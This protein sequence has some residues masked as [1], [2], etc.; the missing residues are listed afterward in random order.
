MR[1]DYKHRPEVYRPMR[2]LKEAEDA[3]TLEPALLELIRIRASQLN[4]CARCLEIHAKDAR[5]MGEDPMRVDLV[6]AWRETQLYSERE[7]AALAWTEELTLLTE[8]TVPDELYEAT[9]AVLS[10]DEVVQ[11]GASA[12]L[13]QLGAEIAPE[14]WC[15][16]DVALPVGERIGMLMEEW[17]SA[18]SGRC[19]CGGTYSLS[20][21]GMTGT[22]QLLRAR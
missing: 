3:G 14:Q 13:E 18:R 15:L 6:A 19:P 22:C 20:E 9:R 4:G 11:D 21:D 10:E 17:N 1:I 2:A 7:R 5:A 16:F 8:R 12:E